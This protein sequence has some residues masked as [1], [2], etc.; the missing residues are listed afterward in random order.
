LFSAYG[1]RFLS[2]DSRFQDDDE[3]LDIDQHIQQSEHT[4]HDPA[5]DD[6]DCEEDEPNEDAD[7]SALGLLERVR[8][9][10][11]NS[12]TKSATQ[13]QA[14]QLGK[15]LKPIVRGAVWCLGGCA[16]DQLQL[17]RFVKQHFIKSMS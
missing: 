5:S 2:A 17:I 15:S 16:F 11:A 12:R 8:P 13:Q 14:E 9:V 10:Q 1:E 4:E 6:S 7:R 3:C